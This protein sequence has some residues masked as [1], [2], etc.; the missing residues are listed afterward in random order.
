M[1]LRFSN[2]MA[3]FEDSGRI[4]AVRW[5]DEHLVHAI[6]SI[7]EK[8]PPEGTIQIRR[9]ETGATPGLPKSLKE[10]HRLHVRSVRSLLEG[11]MAGLRVEMVAF[12]RRKER[13]FGYTSRTSPTADL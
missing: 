11:P 3:L 10:L 8:T 2:R 4:A 9:L 1:Y 7:P 13:I 12:P 6:V 5:L